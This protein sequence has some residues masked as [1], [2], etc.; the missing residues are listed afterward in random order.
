MKGFSPELQTDTQTTNVQQLIKKFADGIS[1]SAILDGVL[2]KDVK[3]TS[4]Q[5]NTVGHPLGRPIKG[6]IPVRLSNTTVVYDSPGANPR[7]SK[8]FIVSCTVD[9]TVTFWVF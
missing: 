9:A 8:Q 6:Y 3:L 4:G 2:V 1:S 5:K 7:P